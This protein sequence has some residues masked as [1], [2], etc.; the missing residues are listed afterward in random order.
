MTLGPTTVRR[1]R[2]PPCTRVLSSRLGGRVV[3][4]GV[5]TSSD[6]GPLETEGKPVTM[7][8]GID[9]CRWG[10]RKGGWGPRPVDRPRNTGGTRPPTLGV[11]SL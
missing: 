3:G 10:A 5:T 8:T 11:D 2:R 7:E 1:P 4:S 6:V 9:C